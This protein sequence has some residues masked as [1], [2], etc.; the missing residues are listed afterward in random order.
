[1]EASEF[2]EKLE[3]LL[4]RE[5]PGCSGLVSV[6]RLSGGA[7]QESAMRRRQCQISVQEGH[8]NQVEIVVE[9]VIVEKEVR[10]RV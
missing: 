8:Q 4:V 1:M 6:E 10:R 5:I 2:Q 7:S 9:R 3:A